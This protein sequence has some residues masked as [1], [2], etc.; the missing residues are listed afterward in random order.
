M[1]KKLLLG[2]VVLAV[3][4][5]AGCGQ[6]QETTTKATPLWDRNCAH[7]HNGNMAV[8]KDTILAKHKD[9]EQF[10]NAVKE[11][12]S[13]GRMPPNLPYGQV[14]DELYK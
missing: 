2:A 13:A 5:I 14:A 1:R 3:G 9:K 11:F 7:C 12:V 8:T 6:K 10:L 4:V